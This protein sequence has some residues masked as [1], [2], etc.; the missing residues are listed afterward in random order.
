MLRRR[1]ARTVSIFLPV[2][3]VGYAWGCARQGRPTGGP[4]D[5]IPPMV[6]STWPDTFA[7]VEPTRDPIVITF[8]ERISERPTVGR[9]D[10]VVVVSPETGQARVKHTRSGLEIS[11]AGGLRPG[12]VY[13]VRVLN[14][15]KDMF[16]NPMVGPFE[17]VFSTGGAYELNVLAGV[18]TDR[19]TGEKVDQARVE[20]REIPESDEEEAGEEAA[21]DS[22]VPVYVARTDTAGIFVLRYIPSGQYE[23]TIYQDNNRNREPDFRERQGTTTAYLGLLP[24]RKDTII[25][26]VALLQP[27]T[28]PARLVRVEAEDSALIRLTFDDFLPTPASLSP[29]R[30]TLSREEGDSPG[31]E[32]LLWPHQL[33]SLRAFED[34]VR[35]ADSLAMVADSLRGVADSLQM[36][37]ADLEAVGDTVELPGV[38]A[39]LERLQARLEPPER[40]EP[41]EEEAPPP[42]PPILPEPE[43][44]AFLRAPLVPD[45]V[46]QVTVTNVRNINGL[47]GGGGEGEVTWEPPEPPPADTAGALPDSL[48]ARPD[49]TAV[50]PDTTGVPPD[51]TG[52]PPDTNGALPGFSRL[53]PVLPP[54]GRHE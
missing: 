38:R 49:T 45:Q 32:R 14:T 30:I 33:D 36:V 44:F 22:D 41:E 17:L 18:V 24:P 1:L 27:D 16:N 8:S 48:A 12:L 50:P 13:R 51:T 40:G 11:L 2:I 43:F 29:I 10:D 35:V 7:T 34:S 28:I 39:A 46:Y 20:A 9:L 25:R 3:A 54:H 53:R 47:M 5:R 21:E 26:E 31:I 42:P 6:V 23:M 37:V 52:V 15:V 19:I 4:Q